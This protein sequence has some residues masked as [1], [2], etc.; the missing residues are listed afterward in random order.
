MA[1]NY[2]LGE[3]AKRTEKTP[4]TLMTEE[5]GTG[6]EF[7][8]DVDK[9]LQ[10]VSEKHRQKSEEGV[11]VDRGGQALLEAGKDIIGKGKEALGIAKQKAVDAGEKGVTALEGA[12]EGT[13]QV[14]EDLNLP[15]FNTDKGKEFI[16]Q[17]GAKGAEKYREAVGLIDS[18]SDIALPDDIKERF[19]VQLAARPDMSSMSTE[20]KASIA[21][22][23]E[24]SVDDAVKATVTLDTVSPD[25]EE[26]KKLWDRFADSLGVPFEYL[27][28][29][30]DSFDEAAG[31]V[32]E[33]VRGLIADGLA[34]TAEG[35]TW[36]NSKV[37]FLTMLA[38]GAAAG[39]QSGNIGIAVV[40]G[41]ASG[42]Q[43][44]QQQAKEALAAKE[45]QRRWVEE[46]NREN[47]KA[48][49]ARRTQEQGLLGRQDLSK[50]DLE[51]ATV[52]A[53][54][55][56]AT[57]ADVESAM[58]ELKASG[59]PATIENVKAVLSGKGLTKGWLP[60]SKSTSG[61]LM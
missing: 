1:Y 55:L 48:L 36:L 16:T 15:K 19:A 41:L 45:E 53:D 51:R 49:T 43:A 24:N 7:L 13:K 6:K 3:G 4:Y 58:V 34:S 23:I 20:E 60:F 39:Q 35:A 30:W 25:T 17:Y 2:L 14:L 27:K 40:Q 50:N 44:R 37:D 32:P 8:A 52:L 38:A 42:I 61:S 21:K 31:G 46:N 9:E 5:G 56:K 47:Y 57:Q 12:K 59:N 11:Y 10:K 28:D 54:Q 33:G 26:G 18:I 22:D 29:A